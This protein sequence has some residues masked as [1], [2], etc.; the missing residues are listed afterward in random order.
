MDPT[1]KPAMVRP[2]LLIVFIVVVLGGGGY[3]GWYFWSKSKTT[4]ATTTTPSTST[5]KPATTTTASETD[6]L[7][8]YTNET[9]GFSFKYPKTYYITEGLYDNQTK[10]RVDEK[11]YVFVDKTKPADNKYVTQSES[12]AALIQF[13]V[14]SPFDL[15]VSLTTGTD[16]YTITEITIAGERAIKKVAKTASIMDDSYRSSIDLNHS[17]YGLSIGWRNTDAAGTHDTA[18]DDILNTFQFK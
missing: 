16:E 17:T 8:V 4:P 7:L 3:F 11:K 12:G 5:T 13:V 1:S 9:Y 18:V 10:T 15:A 6:D 14:V 2:W